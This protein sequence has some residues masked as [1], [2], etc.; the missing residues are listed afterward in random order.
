M[1]DKTKKIVEQWE[2]T[3]EYIESLGYEL[4]EYSFKKN[5]NTIWKTTNIPH[6]GCKKF[7]GYIKSGDLNSIEI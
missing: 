5:K 2:K 6:N 3:K 7:I 4:G 1:S